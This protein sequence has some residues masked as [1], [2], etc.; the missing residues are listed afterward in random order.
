MK[1]AATHVYTQDKLYI[2]N[3]VA[4]DSAYLENRGVTFEVMNEPDFSRFKDMNVMKIIMALPT[5]AD[6]KAM[7]AAAEQRVDASKLAVTY[8]SDRYV[9]F[10]PAGVNKGSATL[11]LGKLLGITADEIIAAGDNGNDLPMLNAV[12]LPVSVANGID[13]LKQQRSM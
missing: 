2:Y 8:S 6:R 10:N 1:R 7:R 13:T 3:P 9:E 11:Q 12:G 4:S 5:M